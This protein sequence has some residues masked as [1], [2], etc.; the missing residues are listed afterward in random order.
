[1][2]RVVEDW[3]QVQ[4]DSP[5]EAETLAVLLPQVISVFTGS[6]LKGDKPA[7]Q[8][9]PPAGAIEDEEE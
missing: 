4:A 3:V 9:V 6:A 7:G 8:Y 2:R 1:M 5:A